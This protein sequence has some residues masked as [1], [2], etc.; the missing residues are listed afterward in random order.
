VR[1]VAGIAATSGIGNAR[2]AYPRLSEAQIELACLCVKANPRRGRPKRVA[3][4]LA[5]RRPRRSNTVSVAI[6]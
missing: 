6:D 1:I 3:E 5:G 2:L 4:V